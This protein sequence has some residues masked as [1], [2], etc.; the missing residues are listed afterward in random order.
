MGTMGNNK[1][2]KTVSF[3]VRWSKERVHLILFFNY[4][5][6]PFSG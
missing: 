5:T 6:S 1:S 2:N 4:L 3:L